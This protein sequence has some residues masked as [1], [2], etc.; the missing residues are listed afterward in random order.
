[1][2]APKGAPAPVSIGRAAAE[3]LAYYKSS[4][5]VAAL[6][7]RGWYCFGTY[8]S[9][10]D[11]LFVSPTPIN[12]SSIRAPD[13]SGMD[14]PAIEVSYRFGGTSGRFS[15]AQ[16][17]ARVFPDEKDFVNSVMKEGKD[18]FVFGPYPADTLAYKSKTVVE[19]ATPAQSD[20]LGTTSWLKKNASPI[21]GA[22]IVF[23]GAE[24]DVLFLAVRLPPNLAG[25]RSAILQHFERT[26]H[27]E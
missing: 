6:A 5:D 20:G 14:G 27:R 22:A 8:G 12:A 9:A 19:Y 16:T 2:A 23:P 7:P 21:S 15:V 3:K 4:Q 17:L 10:G 13:W 1:M 26:A 11:T 25:L 24:P 18:Q